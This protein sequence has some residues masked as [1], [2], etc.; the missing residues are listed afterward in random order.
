MN[1]IFKVIWNA[2]L[3]RKVVTSELGQSDSGGSVASSD[4]TA[5]NDAQVANSFTHNKLWQSLLLAGAVLF[6]APY[7][8]AAE[9]QEEQSLLVKPEFRYEAVAPF[10]SLGPGDVGN[11]NC[12]D[13]TYNS[14]IRIKSN[15]DILTG[16]FS[17]LDNGK[18]FVFIGGENGEDANVTQFKA[19]PNSVFKNLTVY[20]LYKGQNGSSRTVIMD[21]RVTNDMWVQNLVASDTMNIN[22]NGFVNR[23]IVTAGA[24]KTVNLTITGSEKSDSN[25]AVV[26]RITFLN[27][28]EA[29]WK[30]ADNLNLTFKSN[31]DYVLA[32]EIN[33]SELEGHFDGKVTVKLDNMGF[34]YDHKPASADQNKYK[35]LFFYGASKWSPNKPLTIQNINSTIAVFSPDSLNDKVTI[36]GGELIFGNRNNIGQFAGTPKFKNL[37]GLSRVV[38]EPGVQVDFTQMSTFDVNEVLVYYGAKPTFKLPLQGKGSWN[39]NP[40][41]S[42]QLIGTNPSVKFDLDASGYQNLFLLNS[43]IKGRGTIEFDYA[44]KAYSELRFGNNFVNN[45]EGGTIKWHWSN[46]YFDKNSQRVLD[47]SPTLDVTSGRLILGQKSNTPLYV[48][49]QNSYIDLSKQQE[50]GQVFAELNI[51]GKGNLNRLVVNEKW[52]GLGAGIGNYYHLDDSVESGTLVT[53][54]KHNTSNLLEQLTL[55]VGNENNMA[56]DNTVSTVSTNEATIT[57]NSRLDWRIGSTK[58]LVAKSVV[59]KYDIKSGK[60]LELSLGKRNNYTAQQ[61]IVGAGNLVINTNGQQITMAGS[62]Y[63]WQGTTRFTGGGSIVLNRA[64]AQGALTLD[65]GTLLNLNGKTQNLSS[66][67]NSGEVLFNNESLT[68]NG[69]STL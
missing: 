57:L 29:G 66:L 32:P 54:Q 16:D 31:K 51:K 47:K 42:I 22:I 41:G 34:S 67:T 10:A 6:G 55:T 11:N 48:N 62:N 69:S 14:C 9:V 8:G 46:L 24:T 26:R 12:P 58:D 61:D 36:Q 44:N 65:S 27:D 30:N 21:G 3:Q 18:V 37:T 68:L 63:G 39:T 1:K 56:T 13:Y 25:F 49:A 45:Y 38:I 59:T 2:K 40:N 53:I 33:F 28:T 23:L 5:A 50:A 15:D 60:T 20:G 19:G 4:V 17:N 35:G 7:A 43:A 52:L 64:I